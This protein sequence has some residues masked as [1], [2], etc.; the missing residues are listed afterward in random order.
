MYIV[1]C[2]HYTS[3]YEYML[4]S[5][6]NILTALLPGTL[7]SGADREDIDI[8]MRKEIY[9]TIIILKQLL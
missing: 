4:R 3:I 8:D 7:H 2:Y 5:Y 1:I 9:T 6:K